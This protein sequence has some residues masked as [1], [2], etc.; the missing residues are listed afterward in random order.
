MRK[1]LVWSVALLVVALI[2]AGCTAQDDSPGHASAT[3]SAPRSSAVTAPDGVQIATGATGQ[4]LAAAVSAALFVSAPIVVLVPPQDSAAITAGAGAATTLGVPLLI[5]EPAPDPASPPSNSPHSA[6]PAAPGSSASSTSAAGASSAP[7][8]SAAEVTRLGAS[9]VLAV[10]AVS[11]EPEKQSG[12]TIIAAGGTST[13]Q[14]TT[15]LSRLPQTTKPAPLT[16]TTVLVRAGAGPDVATAT[17]PIA[18]ATATAAGARVIGVSSFDPR[19]DSAAITALAQSPTGPVL[20]A[21]TEFGPLA[22]LTARLAVARTGVQLPGG[23]QVM[24]PGR[25]LVALYGHPGTAALGVLG[26]QGPD[27]AVA[28][29][30][31]VAAPYDALYDVP[32]VPTFEIIATVAS[33]APGPDGNYSNEASVD[34][35]MPMVQAATKAGMYVVLDLQPGRADVLAQAQRYQSLLMGPN[36]GLALDPEW[37]LGP[38]QFPLQQIGSLDAATINTVTAWLSQLTAAAHLPQK[39]L[40]L[41]QFK[42][43]MIGHEQQLQSG[44]DQVAVLIHADGQG[45]RALKEETWNAIVQHA[46]AGIWYGWKNFYDEDPQMASP[47]A[48]V[49]RTPKPVMISYQ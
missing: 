11:T 47:A 19:A 35:L 46:P 34:T 8:P 6:P 33:S 25:A 27:A 12:A 39:V 17:A 21:G 5:G 49:N 14:M 22:Q 1:H 38:H 4:Q 32:V 31:Q 37:A 36:V 16:Q 43:S 3:T 45:A 7:S 30:A 15:A 10:G 29:A 2:A 23:G 42:L 9:T 13:K 26:E 41:H 48:T 28:R 24:F 40:V 18:Q 44:T 20:A